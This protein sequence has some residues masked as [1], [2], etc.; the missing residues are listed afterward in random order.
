VLTSDVEVAADALRRGDVVAVPTD[1]VYGLAVDPW[2]SG[3]CER[4]FTLKSRPSTAALPVLVGCL[5]QAL[6]LAAPSAQALLSVIAPVLWPGA[7]TVVV[8]RAA[9]ACVDL[10]GDAATIGIRWP[11]HDLVTQLCSS[12]GPLAVTSANRHGE[13]PC[14]VAAEVV[15]CFGDGVLVLDGGACDGDPSTVVSLTGDEPVLLREGPVPFDRVAAAAAAAARARP[16]RTRARSVGSADV[17]STS[18]PSRRGVEPEPL[19]GAPGADD[20]LEREP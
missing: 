2:A 12:V 18:G 19:S 13:P 11:S 10:G 4:I 9:G 15:V 8:E 7:V 20:P 5:E 6:E 3:A 17:D 16:A 1:T 14:T